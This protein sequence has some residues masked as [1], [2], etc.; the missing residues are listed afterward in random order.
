[1]RAFSNA[2]WYR[3]SGTAQKIG[4]TGYGPNI[5]IVRDPRFGRNSELASEDP[6]LSGMYAKHMVI[7]CQEPD[8][9][10]HP[11]MIALLKHFTAYST[12]HGRGHDTYNI[13]DFDLFDTYLP[14][15]EIAFKEGRAS[16]AM[17]SYNAE[18]GHPSCANGRLL[19]GVI[20][21]LWNQP[22]ALISTD[23]GAVNNLKGPPVNAP[24]DEAAGQFHHSRF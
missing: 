23:C 20:R 18:N 3:N 19:D 8:S 10:G 15:Y 7:G 14:Q 11:R 21:K 16:G 24:T 2:N 5:N 22:D 9:N 4:V 1:M 12:E 6:F 17:C 13:S